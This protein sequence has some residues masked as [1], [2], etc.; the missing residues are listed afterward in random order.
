M[1]MRRVIGNTDLAHYLSVHHN[2]SM[3][4]PVLLLL[5][6][7]LCY[8]PVVAQKSGKKPSILS[9]NITFSDYQ[10]PASIKATSLQEALQQKDWYKPGS[11]SIGL[12]VAWWKQ[13]HPYIDFSGGITGTF[14]SFPANFVADDPIGQARFST[15]LDM[16]LHLRAFKEQAT[17]NPFLTAGLGAGHFPGKSAVYAPLG[18]GIQVKFKEGA[19]LQL[20]AQW[21]KRLSNGIQND[22]L[23]YSIGFAQS[24]A[25]NRKKTDVTTTTPEPTPV[26]PPDADGDGWEDAKDE[27]PDLKGSVKGCPD[28]DGDGIADKLDQCPTEAGKLN[29][30]PD[31]DGDGIAN[32]DDQCPGVAG[33]ERYKGCPIPDSDGD[34]INDEEDRCPKEAGLTTN[35][36]CPEIKPEIKEKVNYAARNILFR[37]ASAELLPSSIKSLNEVVQ[38]LSDNPELKLTIEAHADNR[39]T[40]ER[41]LM[42]SER[43]AKAVADYFISKGINPE[44]LNWKGYGDTQPLADN[45][46][47]KGRSQNRR[48]I[49]KL[50]Y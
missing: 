13:I 34:G 41:N 2:I 48:V 36:G 6:L 5:T 29:G 39:G 10:L 19:F 28:T 23:H 25:K 45:K 42:W 16:L 27:C 18:T 44:R 47:E 1:K 20:Q 31:D 17:F 15:Q 30:C 26:L 9:Y 14:S 35:N 11:K 43:R 46:T 12:S 4:V 7:V 38:I 32:K 22:Y 33:L 37:F 8:K 40:P 24:L 3:K 21:R 50:D 49:M